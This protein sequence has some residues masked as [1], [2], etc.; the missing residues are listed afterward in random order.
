[1]GLDGMPGWGTGLFS[2]S[3]STKPWLHRAQLPALLALGAGPVIME[4]LGAASPGQPLSWPQCCWLTGS[5]GTCA[6]GV[7]AEG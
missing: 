5:Q 6:L 1:M 7:R 3:P 4:V 2:I